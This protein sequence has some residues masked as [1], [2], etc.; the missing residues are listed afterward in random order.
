METSNWN[1]LLQFSFKE[2]Q[3]RERVCRNAGDRKHFQNKEELHHRKHLTGATKKLFSWNSASLEHNRSI[4]RLPDLRLSCMF[5]HCGQF[6]LFQD[7][8]LRKMALFLL[9]ML[10]HNAQDNPYS[11]TKITFLPSLP[12]R[13]LSR[14]DKDPQQGAPRGKCCALVSLPGTGSVWGWLGGDRNPLKAELPQC[15]PPSHP[16][17][18]QS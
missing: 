18:R 13:L 11:E 10:F 12:C 15:H 6:F 7:A 4:Q 16:L 14:H 2:S 9:L 1:I 8:K 17:Q 5:S 3:E